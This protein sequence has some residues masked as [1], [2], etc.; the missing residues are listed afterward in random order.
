MLN[1]G[2]SRL[3]EFH[4]FAESRSHILNSSFEVGLC[5]RGVCGRVWGRVCGQHITGEETK[6]IYTGKILM[7]VYL[8]LLDKSVRHVKKWQR[9]SRLQPTIYI[10]GFI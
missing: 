6:F 3:T 8:L 9:L 7:T 1:G 5:L 2:P 10:T 4:S